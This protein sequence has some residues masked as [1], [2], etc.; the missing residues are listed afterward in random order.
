MIFITGGMSQGKT[1]FAHNFNL[2]II[3]NLH[4]IIKNWLDNSENIE[5]NIKNL[6]KK[7][8]IVI[9]CQEIGCGIVPMDKNER[10]WR[11]VTG[12]TAC[13]IAKKAEKVFKL[14]CGIA[15]QIK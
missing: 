12:R 14:D 2:E 5:E 10:V 8:D 3:D 15:I 9:I 7:D 13:I 11:E 4:I 1:T 6:L